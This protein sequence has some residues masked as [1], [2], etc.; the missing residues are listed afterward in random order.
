MLVRSAPMRTVVLSVVGI[1]LAGYV[2]ATP[3]QEA[4]AGVAAAPDIVAKFLDS[5][6]PLTSYRARRT[7]TAATRG[8]KMQASLTAWTSLT[9]AQGFEFEILAE[10]GSKMIRDKVLRPALEAEG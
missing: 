7:L 6:S 9:P 2:V 3:A 1:L 10:E 5:D 8:G 4:A